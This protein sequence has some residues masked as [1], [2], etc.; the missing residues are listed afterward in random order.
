METDIL[1]RLFMIDDFFKLNVLLSD[2]K[3]FMKF[4]LKQRNLCF[5]ITLNIKIK[6]LVLWIWTKKLQLTEFTYISNRCFPKL[7]NRL[8]NFALF[9]VNQNCPYLSQCYKG[10]FDKA[11]HYRNGLNF[12]RRKYPFQITGAENKHPWS[13]VK[14]NLMKKVLSGRKL[15]FNFQIFHL[16]TRIETFQCDIKQMFI[17]IS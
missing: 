15:F 8:N 1:F 10:Y 7:K 12:L 5:S 4:F 16:F 6:T 14:I 3:F 2:K 9:C 11:H 17:F 13:L